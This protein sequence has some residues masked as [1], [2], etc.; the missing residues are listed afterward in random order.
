MKKLL[1]VLILVSAANIFVFANAGEQSITVNPGGMLSIDLGYTDLIIN[2]WQKNEV[3]IRTS[4][5][6]RLKTGYNNNQVI[7]RESA[8]GFTGLLT[9]NI[10]YKF[11]INIRLGAGNVKI[12]G[13][14]RGNLEVDNSGGEIYFKNI[15]GTANIN[16]GGGSIH[17]SNIKGSAVLKSSG[18]DIS[19]EVIDGP[20]SVI[21]G[22]GDI[23]LTVAEA[24]KIIRTSG[25]NIFLKRASGD[26]EIYSGGGNVSVNQAAGKLKIK[27]SGGDIRIDGLKGKITAETINGTL[28]LKN[29]TGS[30]LARTESGDIVADFKQGLSDSRLLTGNGSVRIS[31]ES[32]IGVKIAVRTRDNEWWDE[33]STPG[34]IKSDFKMTSLRKNQST[35]QVEANYILNGGGPNIQIQAVH[36]EIVIRKN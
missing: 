1:V 11:N 12:N 3:L 32:R 23:R 35:R 18:G 27:S 7:I 34:N 19:A 25:G 2:V 33:N 26:G 16:T 24:V 8:Q 29:I 31:L 15:T 22:G 30:I 21:T 5:Y 17:G 20:T 4:E 14:L 10:P 13:D 9:I 36:G 6:Q 28:R